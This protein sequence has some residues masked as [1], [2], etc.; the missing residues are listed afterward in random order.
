MRV[1]E[2][3][4][5]VLVRLSYS[6]IVLHLPLGELWMAAMM[7]FLGVALSFSLFDDPLALQSPALQFVPHLLEEQ[8]H[9]RKIQRVQVLSLPPNAQRR[10]CAPY[11]PVAE[12]DRVVLLSMKLPHEDEVSW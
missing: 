10:G 3:K 11:L 6:M 8:L 1:C 4:Y 12:R 9:G 7:Q 2:L 5:V